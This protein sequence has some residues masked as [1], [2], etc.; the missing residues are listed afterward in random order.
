MQLA[1][2]STRFAPSPGSLVAH[3]GGDQAP[4]NDSDADEDR[5]PFAD[6]DLDLE[7]LDLDEFR[8]SD[9]FDS[10]VNIDIGAGNL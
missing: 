8:D 5:E 1:L 9:K 4:L 7:D 6:L 10:A 2:C 3:F